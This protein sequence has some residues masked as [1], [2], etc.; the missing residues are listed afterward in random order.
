M[1]NRSQGATAAAA[2][3]GDDNNNDVICLDGA[4]DTTDEDFNAMFTYTP[5]TGEIL[6]AL[7]STKI[8]GKMDVKKRTLASVGVGAIRASILEKL[9]DD[10]KK[11][12][13]V[14][15]P[16]KKAGQ[17]HELKL[18]S[19]IAV[20]RSWVAVSDVLG[21]LAC[22]DSK[23]PYRTTASNDLRSKLIAASKQLKDAV[24]AAKTQI[25]TEKQTQVKAAQVKLAITQL[26]TTVGFGQGDWVVPEDPAH[27]NCLFCNH[28]SI[29]MV[30]DVVG[31]QQRNE[32]KTRNYAAEKKAFEEAKASNPSATRESAKGGKTSRAP[33]KPN[34]EPM[35]ARCCCRSFR[36]VQ[37][38]SDLAS[39]CPIRCVNQ[40]TGEAY[41]D[42]GPNGTECPYCR[43][44]C[45][46]AYDVSIFLYCI[47]MCVLSLHV[48]DAFF[49]FPQSQLT[50]DPRFALFASSPTKPNCLDLHV[51]IT[52]MHAIAPSLEIAKG[53]QASSLVARDMAIQSSAGAMGA[54]L[55]NAASA[56]ANEL[57]RRSHFQ[58]ANQ[59]HQEL[60][61]EAC[62]LRAEIAAAGVAKTM[63]MDQHNPWRQ[64][65]R[66]AMAPN[67]LTSTYHHPGGQGVID[68][69]AF[70]S[71]RSSHREA[72]NSLQVKDP[73][74]VPH[75]SSGTKR[76]SKKKDYY[77]C[78]KPPITTKT[79]SSTTKTY[80]F[81]NPFGMEQ[82][83]TNTAA[84]SF[85]FPAVQFKQTTISSTTASSSS[86]AAASSASTL[87]DLTYSPPE[88][89]P[90]TIGQ[91]Q[92]VESSSTTRTST[93]YSPK[94]DMKKRS[95]TRLTKASERKVE[96]YDIENNGKPIYKEETE[97]EKQER[98]KSKTTLT[99]CLKKDNKALLD[100]IIGDG[101]E[102]QGIEDSQQMVYKLQ[103]IMGDD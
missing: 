78:G 51:Q 102:N 47:C 76:K 84:S 5:T 64:A 89:G 99:A 46:A 72:T 94:T 68:A 42:D 45:A 74:K 41:K 53:D 73:A 2:A 6:D 19:A 98:K 43:C 66:A 59:S 26:P 27:A 21:R 55:S 12:F 88:K 57:A 97:E 95:I 29:D 32:S 3:A 22:D 40:E 18:P 1:A 65:A 9:N 87:C 17:Q 67:G 35:T 70:A 15:L 62:Q 103:D 77:P 93:K 44:Q 90:E 16:L 80:S 49:T 50:D 37:N 33:P 58:S 34:L 31:I 69:R 4:G 38:G 23:W 20:S 85:S 39:T 24:E 71:S 7:K 83:S 63:G 81:N 92:A 60:Q 82:G 54:I 28:K 61:Q 86:M 14:A 96:S 91:Y 30:K 11:A 100:H 75:K 79:T 52:K 10:D 13:E 8:V 56:A 48:D 36:R 101:V 25:H